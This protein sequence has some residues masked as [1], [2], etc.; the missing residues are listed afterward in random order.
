MP[1]RLSAEPRHTAE[2]AER[3]TPRL[4]FATPADE[5]R[6]ERAP[7]VQVAGE[8]NDSAADDRLMFFRRERVLS[9]AAD[10]LPG[11]CLGETAYSPVRCSPFRIAALYGVDGV[12][13]MVRPHVR[14]C[15]D[16]KVSRGARETISHSFGLTPQVR[17]AVPLDDLEP[18]VLRAQPLPRPTPVGAVPGTRDNY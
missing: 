7:F 11:A 12:S 18:F 8:D 17:V 14:V 5:S 16:E 4:V 9:F 3:V 2:R 6:V 10:E 1:E 13:Q 15:D